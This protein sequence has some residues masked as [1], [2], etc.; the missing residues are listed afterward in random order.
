M[1]V[2]EANNE[3][4]QLQSEKEHEIER[5]L[6]ELSSL[7]AEK[8]FTIVCNYENIT[9]LAFIYAGAEPVSYTHLDVY[10]RQ[11]L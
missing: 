6:W 1:R 7:V 2:V 4:R 11:D 10:K 3:L 9:E 8:A 5:I